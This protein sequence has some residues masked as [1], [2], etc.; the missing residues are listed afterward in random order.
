MWFLIFL[1]ATDVF[2][3]I[4]KLNDMNASLG[5]LTLSIV[6]TVYMV[7]ENYFKNTHFKDFIIAFLVGFFSIFVITAILRVVG[8]ENDM[9][10]LLFGFIV[11]VI[12][13]KKIAKKEIDEN[14][15]TDQN[16]SGLSK[17][18]AQMFFEEKADGTMI[19][20][21]KGLLRKGYVVANEEKKMALFDYQ[22]RIYSFY[23]P[24]FYLS[25]LIFGLVGQPEV[26]F[27]V[28]IAG[29]ILIEWHHRKLVKDLPYY[30]EKLDAIHTAK[31]INHGLPS[32]FFTIM[33]ICGIIAVILGVIISF[34]EY[35]DIISLFLTIMGS[36]F[37]AFWWYIKRY[38][39]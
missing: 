32:W 1:T 23:L 27:I 15:Y 39:K 19:Y 12:T 11:G 33:L 21:A 34:K 28:V 10:I 6:A 26:V 13:Y 22:K 25:A 38:G 8:V 3:S 9:G 29:G 4:F 31:V 20:Y 30:G 24:I 7:V 2:V 37:I 5:G 18:L 16:S 14:I 17:Y 36:A 35:S